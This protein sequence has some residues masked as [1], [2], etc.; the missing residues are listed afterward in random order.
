[1]DRVHIISRITYVSFTN[2]LLVLRFFI[3]SNGTTVHWRT[4]HKLLKSLETFWSVPNKSWRPPGESPKVF[5]TLYRVVILGDAE[6]HK[7]RARLG[8]FFAVSPDVTA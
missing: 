5:E 1:M 8:A 6:I 4:E 3:N 7:S 2:F